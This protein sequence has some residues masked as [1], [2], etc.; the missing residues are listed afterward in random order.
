MEREVFLSGYCRCLDQSRMV[1]AVVEGSEL[2]EVDCRFGSCIYEGN[3]PI[4][5]KLRELTQTA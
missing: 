2:L 4:A 1:E 5:E 3:C